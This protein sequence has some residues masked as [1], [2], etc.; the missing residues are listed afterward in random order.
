[1]FAYEGGVGSV[2]SAEQEAGSE[3][4]VARGRF[5]T[6]AWGYAVEGEGGVF[7]WGLSVDLCRSNRF[8]EWGEVIRGEPGCLLVL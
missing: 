8:E 3:E 1:M 4:G 7:P 2:T 6:E 5:R